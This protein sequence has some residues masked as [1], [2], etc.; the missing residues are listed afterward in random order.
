MTGED[1]KDP[2]ALCSDRDRDVSFYSSPFVFL[3]SL[4]LS[5]T[6][7]VSRVLGRR[8]RSVSRP[9]GGL[10]VSVPANILARLHKRQ[11]PPPRRAPPRPVAIKS[12]CNSSAKRRA[13]ETSPAVSALR[14]QHES[15]DFRLSRWKTGLSFRRII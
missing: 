1:V 11:L 7:G 3:Y 12:H 4:F 6:A 10:G 13:G 9:S 2:N 5:D 15:I 8:G 14:F